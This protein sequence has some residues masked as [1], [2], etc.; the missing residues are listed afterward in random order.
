MSF[1]W[2]KNYLGESGLIPLTY[3]LIG[4]T[5]NHLLGDIPIGTI[6][7]PVDLLIIEKY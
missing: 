4:K 6:V 5:I 7:F 3:N 1:D 2:G